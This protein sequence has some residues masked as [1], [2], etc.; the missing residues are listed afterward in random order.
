MPRGLL[1]RNDP[2]PMLLE[3]PGT[4]LFFPLNS[5]NTQEASNIRKFS[6]ARRAFLPLIAVYATLGTAWAAFAYWIAPGIIVAAY[7]DRSLSVLN[8]IFQG[9]RHLPAEHYLH[10]WQ[11]VAGA[12]QIAMI[13]HLLIVL[14]LGRI[15]RKHKLRYSEPMKTNANTNT[16]LIAFSAVFLATAAITGSRGDYDVQ[17][18]PL[19]SAILNGQ[20]A[21]TWDFTG[22]EVV[23]GYGPLFNALAPMTWFNP[24]F[25]KL[26][27]AFSYLVYVIWLIKEYGQRRGLDAASWPCFC[28]LLLNLFPWVQIAYLGYFDVLVGLACVASVHSFVRRKDLLSGTYLAFGILLKFMPIVIL[29]FLA[30]DGRRFYFRLVGGCIAFVALGFLASILVWGTSTFAPLAFAATRSPIWSIYDVVNSTH[31]PLR[32]IWGTPH[33]EWLEKPL[34]LT[35]GLSVFAWCMVRQ[36]EPSLSATLA[37]LLTLL[38]YRIGFANYYLVFLCMIS[39]WAVSEW[40]RFR[41]KIVLSALLIGYFNFLAVADFA[42]TRQISYSDLVIDLLQFLWGCAILAGLIWFSSLSGRASTQARTTLV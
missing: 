16:V 35:A 13:L 37:I 14:F 2:L 8:R 24:L 21:W 3:R 34:L 31:S 7:G 42:Y 33:A 5:H 15:E 28:L 18:A 39:Y 36:I 41:E 26:L 38:L 12:I 17:Y 19:W 30:F 25:N 29:P 1:L 10:S 4:T 11:V 22:N 6:L 40:H 20:N 32:V 27:F 9:N 23:N